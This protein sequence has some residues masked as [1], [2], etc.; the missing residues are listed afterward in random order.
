[1][2]AVLCASRSG[3]AFQEAAKPAPDESANPAVAGVTASD[4]L[5]RSLE[6]L[7]TTLTGLHLDKWK[8]GSVR[9]EA[10]ANITSI[11]KDLQGTLP[12]LIATADAAPNAISKALPVS[13]NLDA[14]YDVLVR[15]VDGARVAAPGD[16]ADQLMQAMAG[17]QKGRLALNDHLQEMAASTEKQVGALQ[18]A[19][20]KAQTAVPVVCPA[21]APKPTPT[22]AVKKKVVKKKPVT[23]P[24][25]AQPAPAAAPKPNSQ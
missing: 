1:M 6:E 2:L 19:I 25:T 3:L 10:A 24:P 22:P 20:V 21:P 11:Q 4:L 13:R 18:A 23:P 5:Q 7:Q 9:T 16:Q 14:L 17:V 12:S 8:G 15:V